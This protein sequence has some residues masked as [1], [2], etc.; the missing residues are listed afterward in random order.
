[1]N[2]IAPSYQ[3]ESE[4]N[5]FSD[6]NN[7]GCFNECF[8]NDMPESSFVRLNSTFE[9]MWML[10]IKVRCIQM[11][12]SLVALV[13]ILSIFAYNTQ[14]VASIDFRYLLKSPGVSGN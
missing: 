3:Y 4:S 11:L 9:Q 7:D 2:L 8:I 14:R 12:N 1:M 13:N 6:E 5:S 10:K